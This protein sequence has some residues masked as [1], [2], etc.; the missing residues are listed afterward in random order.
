MIDKFMGETRWLSNYEL[1]DVMYNGCIYPS[2]E[3]AFQAA[4]TLDHDQRVAIL[5][6]PTPNAAKK[7]GQKV[8]LRKDWTAETRIDC[9]R[10]ILWD[11][12]TRNK[13]LKEKLIATGD[14]EL[15]EGNN[16]GDRFWGVDGIGE[17]NLG[18][19][20]MQIRTQLK[21]ETK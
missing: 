9:M 12:F 21:E 6:A 2:S 13:D 18:K 4:K 5:R 20:L 11:K 1:C 8:T 7:L 19:I 10:V 14:E 16:W 17:N 3:H 15:I